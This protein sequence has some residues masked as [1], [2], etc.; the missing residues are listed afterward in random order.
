MADV[1]T[2]KEWLIEFEGVNLPIGDLAIH[3]AHDDSFPNT[4][5]FDVLLEYLLHE[6][7]ASTKVTIAFEAAYRYYKDSCSVYIRIVK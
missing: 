2:F 3:A 1:L 4:R 7:K 6:V 5:D